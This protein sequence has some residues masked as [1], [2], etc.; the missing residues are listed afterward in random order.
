MCVVR[1]QGC[2]SWRHS[3]LPLVSVL[4][5]QHRDYGIEPS[6]ST[7]LVCLERIRRPMPVAV[8][9]WPPRRGQTVSDGLLGLLGIH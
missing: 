6:I 5:C 9:P 1:R 4:G 7:V 3:S 8:A 2:D